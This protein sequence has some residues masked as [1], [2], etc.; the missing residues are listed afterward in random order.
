MIFIQ[1]PAILVCMRKSEINGYNSEYPDSR[2]SSREYKRRRRKIR[3]IR[4]LCVTAVLV[5]L[6][7]IIPAV[8]LRIR[9]LKSFKGDYVRRI[10][11]TDQVTA[12]AAVW[13]K[14][15]EGAEIEADWIRSMTDGIYADVCLSFTPDGLSKG[16]FTETL[17]EAS[18]E[19]CR[20]E[21]YRMTCECLK[22]LII[23]RLVAVGY[24]ESMSDDEA[25]ALITEALNMPL[26]SYV[27][28]AG[29]ALIPDYN[30]LADDINRSGDYR[31]KGKA[32]E[33]MRGDDKISDNYSVTSDSISIPDAGFVYTRPEAEDDKK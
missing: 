23:K 14:D 17:D 15:V 31:I 8:V 6:A 19:A 32:I 26:E 30:E 13:L 10:D 9:T 21:A 5:S 22:E 25:D 28:N 33:W 24:A 7:L 2:I 12:N 3:K 27:K 18:Y 20:E 1:P 16:S 11:I 4:R 29:I